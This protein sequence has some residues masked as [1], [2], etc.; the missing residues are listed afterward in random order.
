MCKVIKHFEPKIFVFENV[1]GLIS[2]RWTKDGK[3]GEIF[4]DVKK[5]FNNL[6]N[7][8]VSDFLVHAKDYGVPQNRPRILIIGIRKDINFDGKGKFSNGYLPEPT[9]DYPHPE[10]LLSDLIDENYEDW[11]VTK[12]YLSQPKNGTQAT[13]R[14][15]KGRFKVYS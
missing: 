2:A 5:E 14:T 6:K 3:K 15:K 12:E 7:Y 9:H 1:R 4:E 10:E 11:L 8:Q 13:F